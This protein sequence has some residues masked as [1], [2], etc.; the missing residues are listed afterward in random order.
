[1]R[2]L[3]N[4]ILLLVMVLSLT[5]MAF[6]VDVDG[7]QPLDATP[8]SADVSGAI[9]EDSLMA[10][11]E[12]TIYLDYNYYNLTIRQGTD[13]PLRFSC[14]GGGKNYGYMTITKTDGNIVGSLV[15][16]VD[17]T[18]LQE[19]ALYTVPWDADTSSL[20]VGQYWVMSFVADK[21]G[22]MPDP[23]NYCAVLLNVVSASNPLKSVS[24][25]DAEA[26]SY[27]DENLK[28][29]TEVRLCPEEDHLYG[30]LYNPTNTTTERTMDFTS[31][32]KTV[33]EVDYYSG[34]AYVTAK[35][36]GTATITVT[37]GN[38][39]TANLKV[40]VGHNYTKTVTKK[41]TCSQE[42]SATYTC[43]CGHS[44]TETIPVDTE[45]GHDIMDM[46][47]ITPA[48][49]CNPGQGSG[50]CSICGDAVMCTI[51][52]IFLDVAPDQ[53][54]SEAVDFFYANEIIKG[55]TETKFG[56]D[57]ELT[58][59][60]LVTLLYRMEGSPACSIRTPFTDVDTTQY[61]A[62][63]I[64]WAYQNNLANGT[65]ATTFAPDRPITR[66]QLATFIYRYAKYKDIDTSGAAALT[67]F[68]DYT[69]THDYAIEAISWAVDS[70]IISGV[71]RYGTVFL[72]P[73]GNA[74]RAQAATMLYR[75]I[76]F[77]FENPAP[78]APA[79]PEDSIM[80]WIPKLGSRYH[81]DSTCS[82]IEDPTQ[83]SLSY[84]KKVGYLPCSLCV[85]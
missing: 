26:Y 82:G 47:V 71:S 4:I 40:T 22:N 48:T 66:E 81:S 20:A 16:Y 31:S 24:F 18:V 36:P 45:T 83:V 34:D 23:D 53:Y 38:N 80:V 41:P 61:Y 19:G 28:T 74:T 27:D 59:G 30:I 70:G 21:N 73:L 17:L 72:S 9:S 42:G 51:P 52:A 84:A 37:A 12:P 75:Y 35:A 58:R 54:Y 44:Y 67:D 50:L 43:T 3:R 77:A 60:M 5:V 7:A 39:V 8:Y 14:I 62:V 32:D 79:D 13:L 46:V 2:K 85:K 76:G 65:T 63:P 55:V 68:P 49:A 33:A 64:A 56:K 25:F 69:E 15:R 57:S 29:V 78:E 10:T 1:M 6:A 11:P